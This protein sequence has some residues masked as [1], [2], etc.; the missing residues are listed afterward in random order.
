MLDTT[1]FVDLA[2]FLGTASTGLL[3]ISPQLTL[4]D[5]RQPLVG[6]SAFQVF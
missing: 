1:R 3:N 2:A 5:F 4:G 6:T